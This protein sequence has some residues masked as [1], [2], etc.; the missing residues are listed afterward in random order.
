MGRA[1]AWDLH[2]ILDLHAKLGI[3][4]HVHPDLKDA[5]FLKKNQLLN[6]QCRRNWN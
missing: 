6:I 5:A 1:P 3:T 2:G 4:I